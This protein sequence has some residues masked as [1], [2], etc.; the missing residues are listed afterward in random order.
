MKRKLYKLTFAAAMAFALVFTGACKDDEE[1]ETKTPVLSVDKTSIASVQAGGT[2]T[3]AVTANVAWAASASE[4]F[5]TLNPGN[6]NGDATVTVTVAA[7]NGMDARTATIT[8][9]G[10]GVDAK[11]VT[12][13]QP[14]T[15]PVL[16]VT[17]PTLNFATSGGEGQ[18]AQITTNVAWTATAPDWIT[19]TPNNGTA[20]ADLTVTVTD[21][22]GAERNGNITFSA[23]GV[24]SQTIA[25]TQAA[26]T[27][28]VDTDEIR[29]DADGTRREQ[30]GDVTDTLTVN[31]NIAWEVAATTLD[32][33]N[34]VLAPAHTDSH[35]WVS[36]RQEGNYL[37]Y[38]IDG[39][40]YPRERS[41]TITVAAIS[42]QQKIIKVTQ[43][44]RTQQFVG[45]SVVGV[46]DGATIPAFTE[47][48]S[49][50]FE[51]ERTF[52][53]GVFKLPLLNAYP[54]A[55]FAAGTKGPTGNEVITVDGPEHNLYFVPLTIGWG[56]EA[57]DLKWE[58]SAAGYYKL[59][60]NLNTMKLKLESATPPPD[61][62]AEL[63][64]GQFW[65][66]FNVDATKTFAG[67]PDAL[68]KFYQFHYDVAYSATDPLT[69]AWQDGS[70]APNSY[71]EAEGGV[72]PCPTGWKLP[73]DGQLTNMINT[74]S[75][76]AAA[77]TKGNA[78]A[79][80]FFGANHAAATISDPQGCIFIPAA[81][82][83]ASTDGTLI[84]AG[85]KGFVHSRNPYY[86]ETTQTLIF[87]E[88][89]VTIARRRNF[90]TN[91]SE[92][93]TGTGMSVRCIKQ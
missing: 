22:D 72:S 45:G 27:F 44:A 19:V 21:N 78:V 85:V 37:L 34:P 43:G 28:E 5:V 39:N 32:G 49:G 3:L 8:V 75:T 23:T 80:R 51:I 29:I 48:S 16:T 86:G 69:P 46:W 33:D 67:A 25:V 2:Y 82:R 70:S 90:D 56:A 74:G 4:T 88:N 40:P 58:I 20:T 42:G 92:I 89:G 30:S 15:T 9:S 11:T 91:G 68:G 38:S 77:G 81:G 41:A 1:Q 93:L 62:N 76:W 84:D 24:A 66:K 18:A 50:I 71:W 53:G 55:Y 61:P 14:G 87:D 54:T 60:V 13:S 36:V 79:G 26:A 65:A 6:G 47:T 17:P 35:E 31:A 73:D 63:I 64:G 57:N 10:E 12:V 7:N 52:S 83:R 59:T